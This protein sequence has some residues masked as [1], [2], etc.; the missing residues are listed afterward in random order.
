M[1]ILIPTSLGG[2]WWWW[3]CWEA[4]NNLL[5]E[6]CKSIFYCH[7]PNLTSKTI[8][9][10]ILI[11]GFLFLLHHFS[12]PSV[13]QQQ[14]GKRLTRSK[15]SSS[16]FEC[17]TCLLC[18]AWKIKSILVERE[19]WVTSSKPMQWMFKIN[20]PIMAAGNLVETNKQKNQTPPE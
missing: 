1:L 7:S 16:H 11:P 10:G 9:C 20:V 13:G 8:L 6:L 18:W 17:H 19:L 12:S 15:A 4:T 2:W 14:L 5:Y 3:W